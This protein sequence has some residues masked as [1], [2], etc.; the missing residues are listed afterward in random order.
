M[1]AQR[2]YPKSR[3]RTDAD[4]LRLKKDVPMLIS[5]GAVDEAVVHRSV[6]SG[7]IL[8]FLSPEALDGL[9][10]G[11]LLVGLILLVMV[12]RLIRRS[13]PGGLFRDYFATPADGGQFSV[14][15]SASLER[16]AAI[17]LDDLGEADTDAYDAAELDEVRDEPTQEEEVVTGGGHRSK[18]RMSTRRALSAWRLDVRRGQPRHAAQATAMSGL[19]A[20]P[21]ARVAPA[22]E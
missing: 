5:S 6:A 7:G 3:N 8:H 4:A 20:T 13:Q 21:P 10:I 16:A 1:N 11:A 12:P 2:V 9:A 14:A 15:L 17:D 18:H 22:R 19:S